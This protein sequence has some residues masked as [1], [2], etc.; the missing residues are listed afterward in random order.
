MRKLPFF[1]AILLVYLVGSVAA[2]Q[3]DYLEYFID[4][5]PGHGN[6][7]EIP[8]TPGL[9]KNEDI[10]IATS[11]LTSGFHTLYV[12][13]Q[14]DA[15]RW[16]HIRQQLFLIQETSQPVQ[17]ILARTE[18]F[19][20]QDPGWGLANEVTL[21]PSYEINQNIIELFND[22]PSGFHSIYARSKSE[23][24]TWG[25][26]HKQLIYK[27]APPKPPIAD[28]S[29]AEYYF[30]ED[31]GWGQGTPI[32]ITAARNIQLNVDLSAD[33]L[34]PGFHMLYLRTRDS[35]GIWSQLDNELFFINGFVP[36]LPTNLQRMEY[37]IDLDPGVG[38][39]NAVN[40]NSDKQVSL[41]SVI[42]DEAFEPGFHTLYMRAFDSLYSGMMQQQLVL[43]KPKEA[44]EPQADIVGVEYFLSKEIHD[45]IGY[46]ESVNPAHEIDEVRTAL[47][48]GVEAGEHIVWM[49]PKDENGIWGHLVPSDTFIVM[50][51]EWVFNTLDT[52]LGSFRFAVNCVNAADTVF[53]DSAVYDQDI[54]L[55]LPKIV[56]NKEVFILADSSSNITLTNENMIDQG[57][58]L[59][60]HE[61]LHLDGL[62]LIGKS[63]SSFYFL[64]KKP[65]GLFDFKGGILDK[66]I[67]DFD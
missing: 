46:R 5:D 37:F 54:V 20:N 38:L 64:V 31:P 12:R 10:V 59:Q 35:K 58:L 16:G 50:E 29:H 40:I 66:L 44:P 47:T 22:K 18:F 55:R 45:S 17:P 53:F 65:D 67:I 49:R 1:M 41:Q 30:D 26:L 60:I 56:L 34:S 3:I 6:G 27:P 36:E 24:G 61:P 13:S 11:Q 21:V 9:D 52:G 48:T 43:I 4:E 25:M 32:G 28:V 51:C 23:N 19:V 15:G 14:D 63:P 33:Q 42:N 8:I 2:Q 62:N 57:A 39:A 7:V